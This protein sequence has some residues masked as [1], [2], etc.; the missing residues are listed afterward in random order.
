MRIATMRRSTPPPPRLRTGTGAPLLLLHGAGLTWQSWGGVIDQLAV[1]HDI[2]APTLPAHWGAPRG[3]VPTTISSMADYLEREMDAAGWT[4]AHIA[5]N[6]LGGWL[7]LELADRG[8]ARTVTA[9]A[10]AGIWREGSKA[11][12]KLRRNFSRL[13][14]IRPLGAVARLPFGLGM[15]L[16]RRTFLPMY[17]HR[18]EL[19]DNRLA[20]SAVEAPAHCRC[21]RELLTFNGTDT[22]API[23]DRIDI[24]VTVLFSGRDRV[25][26]PRYYGQRLLAGRTDVRVK[27]LHDVGH[28][29][30]L[31]APQLLAA[32]IR[33]A[34]AA[35]RHGVDLSAEPP[36]A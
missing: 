6:S 9:V 35:G 16:G 3:D 11:A 36:V 22:A 25:I 21:L 1:D 7:A 32:E 13:D 2:L 14:W 10:P 26:P 12:A 27:T 4:D 34:I 15:A 5:G 24:P 23:L 28:V 17:A 29:P 18:P 31:E 20:L 30:M 19:V 33:S 8:R